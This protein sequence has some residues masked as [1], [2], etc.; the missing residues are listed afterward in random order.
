MTRFH[1]LRTAFALAVAFPLLLQPPSVQTQ[2]A[3]TPRDP[4]SLSVLQKRLAAHLDQPRFAAASWG[5]KIISLDT[6]AKLFE[7]NAGK[8]LKPAS[9]AKLFTGALALDR[10]GPDF[11]IGT[12]VHA[13]APPNAKGVVKGDLIVYGRGD[14]SFAARFNGGDYTKSLEPL[15][16]ALM[17]AG[18][19]QVTGDLIGD[20]SFFRGPPFGSGWTWDDLQEYYGAGVSALTVEDNTV[21]LVFK[22]GASV[23]DACLIVT[24]PGTSSLTFVNRTETAPPGSPRQINLYRPVGEGVVHVTGGLPLQSPAATNAI[25]V[26]DP[27]RWFMTLLKEALIRRGVKVAGRVRTVNSIDRDLA[28]VD[29]SQRVKLATVPSQPL[30]AILPQMMKPSQNLYAQL[31]LLQVGAQ[32]QPDLAARTTTEEAGLAEMSR[33]LDEVGI[34]QGEV[35]LQEGSGLSRS[36][37]L[38]PDAIIALLRHLARHRHA[39]VFRESLPL[40]GVDG[41]LRRRMKG[42]AAEKNVRAKTG[43]LR[44]VNTLSGY[45]TTAAGEHLAFAILRNNYEHLDAKTPAAADLDAIAV[46]LAEFTGHTQP[47]PVSASP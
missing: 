32:R 20:E 16:A 41:S 3:T 30:S 4:E 7:R 24:K 26:P 8:L 40:A 28:P 38:T 25:T 31:L 36:A 22:P 18:V 35:L 6:G 11:R 44:Y 27:A 37:L 39:E 46:M 14:P 19:K 23:G 47:S 9:N 33:F 42:T 45:V 43:T 15:V 29:R 10:L 1:S 5:V 17:N 13:T 34:R 12:S 21:D 2:P